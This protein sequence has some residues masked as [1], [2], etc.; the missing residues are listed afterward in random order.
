MSVHT[1]ISVNEAARRLNFSARYFRNIV[2]RRDLVEGTHYIRA[3]GGRKILI[4]WDALEEELL[5]TSE[6]LAAIPMA[7]GGNCHV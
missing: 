1:Y 4:L 7:S 6:Q 5:K 3:F 2:L